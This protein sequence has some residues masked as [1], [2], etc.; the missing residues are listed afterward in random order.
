MF[1]EREDLNVSDDHHLIVI[2]VKN[3]I[4]DD[5]AQVLFVSLGKVEHRFRVP[6]WCSPQPFAIGIFT[7]ALEYGAHGASKLLLVRCLFFLRR[8]HTLSRALGWPTQSVKV[9][10]RML[11]VRSCLERRYSAC[12]VFLDIDLAY[13]AAVGLEFKAVVGV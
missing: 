8:F 13:A 1:A 3:R 9:D 12:I 2:L 7:K 4:V 10:G 11:C 6:L 5:V